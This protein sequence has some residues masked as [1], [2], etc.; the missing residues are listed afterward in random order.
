MRSLVWLLVLFASA[1]AVTLASHNSGYVLLVYPPYRVEMSLA[2]FLIGSV[3]VFISSYV[4]V[5]LVSAAVHLPQYVRSFRAERAQRKGRNAMLEALTAFFEGRYVVAE[6]EAVKAMEFGENSG[7]NSIIA[8]RAANELREFD[9]RDAYLAEAQGKTVGEETMRLMAK[10]E[11]QLEQKLH[12]SALGTLKELGNA[13]LRNHI[14]ALNLELKAQQLARNWDAVLDVANQLEKR[15]AINTTMAFQMRQQ[16]WLEKLRACAN[17]HEMLP[18]VWKNMP[19]EFKHHSM[20]TIEAAHVFMMLGECETARN[21]L[22]ESLNAKWDS[23]LVGLYGNCLDGNVVAQIDQAERWLQE[24]H[25]DAGLLLALGKLCLHQELW[26]K[27]QNYLEA[28]ISVRPS[29]EAYTTLALLS[30]KVHKPDEAFNYYQ[31]ATR[32]P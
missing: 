28:S 29:R 23:E 31:L 12:Q 7:L 26:G 4:L 8:A 22:T 14:G 21:L 18:V 25:E 17:D 5:R 10:A 9:K 20:I 6:K 27:A 11:F 1:V 19:V 13:G 30:E 2:L 24:H 3:I 32:V 15:N 16:A